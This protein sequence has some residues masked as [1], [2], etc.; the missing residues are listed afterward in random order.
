MSA[1]QQSANIDLGLTTDRFTKGANDAKKGFQ[2]I[3]STG[4]QSMV[5]LKGSIDTTNSSLEKT[6][7]VSEKASRSFSSFAGVATKAGASVIGFTSSLTGAI[8]AYNDLEDIQIKIK[9]SNLALSKAQEAV[10]K[11][12]ADGGRESLNYKQAVEKLTIEQD[13]NKEVLEDADKQQVQFMTNMVTMAVTTIPNFIAAMVGLKGAHLGAAGTAGVNAGAHLGF[14]ASLTASTA[15]IWLSLKAMLV[16]P[17]FQIAATAAIAIGV[18]LIASN[19]WGLRDSLEASTKAVVDSNK[20]VETHNK[21]LNNYGTEM[22]GATT[23]VY[24][25]ADGLNA[26]SSS[27][28]IL[29]TSLKGAGKPVRSVFDE[30]NQA[31]IQAKDSAKE[32]NKELD[33]AKKNDNFGFLIEQ[34]PNVQST[35]IIKQLI[36]LAIQRYEDGDLEGAM[37]VERAIRDMDKSTFG[38][39]LHS[40]VT[41]KI[42]TLKEQMTRISTLSHAFKNI[43]GGFGL[44]TDS[45]LSVSQLT[46]IQ[47]QGILGRFGLPALKSLTVPKYSAALAGFSPAGYA[48]AKLSG[49]SNSM[50]SVSAGGS[51]S[52]GRSAS[53]GG[54]NRADNYQR[55]TALDNLTG[56]I[57][58][59]ERLNRI[60]GLNFSFPQWYPRYRGDQYL[61]WNDA[62]NNYAKQI[63]EANARASLFEQLETFAGDPNIL[64]TFGDSGYD[65]TR[66]STLLQQQQQ[67]ATNY[68][69]KLGLPQSE[70]LKLYSSVSGFEDLLNMDRFRSREIAAATAA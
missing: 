19:T 26:A 66:L 15:A 24:S 35:A 67:K 49:G 61:S 58:N 16:H 21:T 39:G 14:T 60:T 68:S 69:A 51:R 65:T 27:F 1:T 37:Q 41:G 3:G 20:A 52:S 22:K 5:Q 38:T 31:I 55:Q 18:G 40:N 59:L 28:D 70:I 47:S 34:Y 36:T 44:L 63:A 2:E 54:A 30:W 56:G 57:G 42:R 33:K 13:K 6:A 12:Y 7:G 25:F 48:A 43:G 64:K 53:H 45:K 46:G 9:Q 23:E 11:A 8:Y 50:K 62:F 29:T 4:K 32:F 10:T 17:F